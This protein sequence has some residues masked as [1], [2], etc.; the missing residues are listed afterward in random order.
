MDPN[1]VLWLNKM[2]DEG[3]CE[4][5]TPKTVH[6]SL[7]GGNVSPCNRKE[8]LKITESMLEQNKL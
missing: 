3:F 7:L 6:N 5:K 8:S 4:K 2:A 1:F